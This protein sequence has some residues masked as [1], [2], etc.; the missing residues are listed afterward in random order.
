MQQN[1]NHSIGIRITKHR[2]AQLLN[3]VCLVVI[4]D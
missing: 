1:L 4:F 3:S 2:S